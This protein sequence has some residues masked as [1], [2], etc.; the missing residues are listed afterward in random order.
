MS[1]E[2]ASAHRKSAEELLDN[3]DK[4][5]VKESYLPGKFFYVNEIFLVPEM[6]AWKNQFKRRS[7]QCQISGLLR[8]E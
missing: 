7:S 4:T 3:L 8:T 2:S 1:D 5:I 6:N